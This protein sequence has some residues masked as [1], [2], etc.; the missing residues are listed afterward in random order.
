MTDYR[1]VLTA[2]DAGSLAPQDFDHRAHIAVAFEAL[3]ED[4]F[5]TASKRIADGLKR[6]TIAAGVPEKF[7]ATITQ[8]YMSAIAEAMHATP[9]EDAEAFLAQNADLLEG[10]FLKER[11]SATCLSSDLARKVALLPDRL[12][13]AA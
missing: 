1:A 9:A 2:L 7:H 3:R 12:G 4:D 6:L 5:F 10:T 13:R 11:Y 8:A